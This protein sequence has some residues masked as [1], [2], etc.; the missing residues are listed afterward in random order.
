M[1]KIF[2]AVFILIFTLPLAA[3]NFRAASG[4]GNYAETTR[5]AD[6]GGGERVSGSS[7]QRE[8]KISNPPRQ[9]VQQQ[10]SQPRRTEYARPPLPSFP[11][12][13]KQPE[14]RP[15]NLPQP[16]R[17]QYPQQSFRARIIPINPA[18]M[19]PLKPLPPARPPIR[20]PSYYITMRPHYPPNI[21][22][23]NTYNYSSV[24]FFTPVYS[25]GYSTNNDN[26]GADALNV[27]AAHAK[28]IDGSGV[29][30]MVIDGGV[31]P[32]SEFL[33]GSV[34]MLDFAGNGVYD[35]R[36]HGTAVIGVIISRGLRVT[37]V[38]P[39][40]KIYSAKADAGSGTLNTANI[41]KAI[42]WAIDHNRVSYDKISIIN[43][44]YGVDGGSVDLA[45]AIQK[46]YAAGITVVAPAGNESANFVMFPAN[47]PEVIAAAGLGPDG[48]AY[49]QTSYGKEVD[50][51]APGQDIY[52]TG[53]DGGYARLDGT[54]M[55]AAYISGLAALAV[56]SYRQQHSG[57]SPSPLQVKQMLAASSD[58]LYA[59]SPLAQG[60]GLPDA[61]RL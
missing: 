4:A 44:S 18:G 20:P 26:W 42:N 36:G 12:Q 61:S 57:Q 40:A 60:Y 16:A 25:T 33:P 39:G 10:Q 14:I 24:E 55:S 3:Q 51:I 47:M 21:Y 35:S 11:V 22:V 45:A 1:K 23:Q 19:R 58:M 31:A 53:I 50:F 5:R 56:Q 34:Q 6:H 37:G 7:V 13:P 30:I 46:A 2:T 27:A 17:P 15:V 28:G 49:D 43:L 8:N 41:V 29:S 32:H 52:T 48:D 54:S 9:H 59:P 38:A